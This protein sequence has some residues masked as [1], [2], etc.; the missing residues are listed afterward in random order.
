M[1]RI[2]MSMLVAA[3]V[4]TSRDVVVTITFKKTNYNLEKISC[5]IKI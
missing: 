5:I 2:A 1:K 4:Y 3:K